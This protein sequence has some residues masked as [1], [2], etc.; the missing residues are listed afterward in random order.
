MSVRVGIASHPR[1]TYD[2]CALCRSHGEA[3]ES[4]RAGA[5]RGVLILRSSLRAPPPDHGKELQFLGALSGLVTLRFAQNW[6]TRRPSTPRYTCSF[7]I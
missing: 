7:E 4:R 1:G 5:G 2:T 3:W 6:H